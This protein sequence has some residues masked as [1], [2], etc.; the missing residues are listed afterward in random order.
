MYA[1]GRRNV[2]YPVVLVWQAFFLEQNADID[3]FSLGE[4]SHEIRAKRGIGIVGRSAIVALPL[5]DISGCSPPHFS[6]IRRYFER[7]RKDGCCF[8]TIHCWLA[9]KMGETE[10]EMSPDAGDP[11]LLLKVPGPLIP[12]GSWA[13]GCM[14]PPGRS[15][16]CRINSSGKRPGPV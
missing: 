11:L 1:N 16:N 7:T 8:F 4:F 15:D 3:E 13:A 6:V 10:A 9:G 2:G 5:V 14:P 12:E